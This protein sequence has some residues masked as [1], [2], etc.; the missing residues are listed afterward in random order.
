[1]GRKQGPRKGSM[2][3][4]PRKRSYDFLPRVNWDSIEVKKAG[5]KANLLGFIGYKAGMA[6]ALVK[7][8]TAD[9]MTKNK[10]KIVPV[11]IVECPTV[12]IFSITITES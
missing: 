10:R 8:N 9:S 12:K 6:S 11:T 5:E 4:W 2:Q 7:D 1:M 3:V